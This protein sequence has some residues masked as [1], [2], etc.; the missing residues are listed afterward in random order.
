MRTW[1]KCLTGVLAATFAAVLGLLAVSS[2]FGAV[3]ATNNAPSAG[4][5]S[6]ECACGSG[7][8]GGLGA[9]SIV[10]TNAY[11][12][13]AT[14]AA[15]S[16]QASAA[17]ETASVA[18]ESG[19]AVISATEQSAIVASAQA[20]GATET[21][22]SSLVEAAGSAGT[23]LTSVAY[24]DEEVGGFAAASELELASE[25]TAQAV[26]YTEEAATLESSAVIEL[27]SLETIS[28]G[29]GF[30]AVS[31]LESEISVVESQAA[32]CYNQAASEIQIAQSSQVVVTGLSS[33]IQASLTVQMQTSAVSESE[34]LETL[35][36]QTNT[37]A[38][39]TATIVNQ[40]Q[41][42]IVGEAGAYAATT[43]VSTSSFVATAFES[44]AEF[45][46]ESVVALQSAASLVTSTTVLT[47]LQTAAGFESQAV[48]A[49]QSATS[50]FGTA[51]TEFEL[52]EVTEGFAAFGTG[53]GQVESAAALDASAFAALSGVLIV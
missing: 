34:V 11:A 46:S 42:E 18:E 33:S 32:G 40:A 25:Y 50:A 31:S 22:I 5:V 19:G 1:Q 37:C 29:A 24:A 51:A 52:S 53:C 26:S 14:E 35:I 27:Q 16:S 3:A 36:E 23:S 4:N 12:T 28:S 10:E 17:L 48:V 6:A 45:S 49:Y 13:L 8:V 15:V 30:A 21:S 39:A 2:A 44:A 47:T 38:G 7:L 9:T 41:I 20:A 43:L